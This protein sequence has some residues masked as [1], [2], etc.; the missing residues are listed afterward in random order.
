M[1]W[2]WYKP[3]TWQLRKKPG[4][5]SMLCY[6]MQQPLEAFWSVVPVI[7]KNVGGGCMGNLNIFSL[8]S[9]IFPENA[10]E[11]QISMTLSAAAGELSNLSPCAGKFPFQF[12]SGR[13]GLFPPKT[14]GSEVRVT[15]QDP[16]RRLHN[17]V[18][19]RIISRCICMR[20]DC[21]R[22]HFHS[23]PSACQGLG[24]IHWIK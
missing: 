1:T 15:V 13:T 4:K 2:N 11:G 5:V 16:H 12:F 23:H 20:T 19:S 21:G 7:D 3:K 17:A 9:R 8:A 22:F 6:V 18:T 14:N 10:G 24:P